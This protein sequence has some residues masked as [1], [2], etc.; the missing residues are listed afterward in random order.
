MDQLPLME[1]D[2]ETEQ[3]LT[4]PSCTFRKAVGI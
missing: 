2:P 4:Y 3:V 1:K